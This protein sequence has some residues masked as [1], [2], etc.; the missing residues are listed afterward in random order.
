L[1]SNGRVSFA[2]VCYGARGDLTA[3]VVNEP[4]GGPVPRQAWSVRTI[5]GELIYEDG[6]FLGPGQS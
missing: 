4:V 3:G 2:P 6:D 5:T 1:P